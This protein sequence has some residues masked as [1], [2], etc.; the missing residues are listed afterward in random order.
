MK[1]RF[2]RRI[3][4]ALAAAP[5]LLFAVT[6]APSGAM[7][8][9]GER[10]LEG[11][12]G[13]YPASLAI[14]AS[15]RLVYDPVRMAIRVGSAPVFAS[16][17][18]LALAPRYAGR[19]TGRFLMMT[20][21]AGDVD[22]R[23]LEGLFDATSAGSAAP[24]LS[25][26]RAGDQRRLWLELDPGATR[27]KVTVLP[28]GDSITQGNMAKW[29][30]WRI[31]YMK[32]LAAAGYDA[33][34]VGFWQIESQDIC[35]AS[36]PSD[37]VWHS[38]ISGQRIRH[39]TGGTG[40]DYAIDAILDQAG[41]DVDI[42]L[43]KLATNDIDGDGAS[44][45]ELYPSW[46]N[47][48]A[49]IA[50]RLPRAKVV[51]ASVLHINK[52]DRNREVSGLNGMIQRAVAGGVF[53][54]AYFADLNAACPRYDA[55]GAY[56]GNF[57]TEQ[58]LHPD[59][60]GEELIADEY[61]RVTELALADGASDEPPPP[62]PTATGARE[63]V[64]P[65]YLAGFSRA[66]VLDVAKL[67]A[68]MTV[69]GEV[70][71][72]NASGET[73]P[74]SGIRRVGYYV[75]LK[76]RNTAQVDYRGR[77]RWLWVDM[78]AFGATEKADGY[79]LADVGVPL[80]ASVKQKVVSRLHVA[81]NMPGVRSVAADDDSVR[82]F[83]EFWP[84]S[85]TATEKT[86]GPV[87]D[88]PRHVYGYDWNDNCTGGSAWGS[89]QVH[90]I[91]E[92]G[93]YP[94][95]TLFAFNRFTRDGTPPFEIGIGNF[96]IKAVKSADWTQTKGYETLNSAAYEIARIEIWTR[97][98]EKEPSTDALQPVRVATFNIR[99]ENS[100]DT[101]SKSWGDRRATVAAVI[102][103]AKPDVFGL[104][105]VLP[106][107]R[108][109][110]A[111]KLP[112]WTLVGDHRNAD[113]TSG[114]ASPVGYRTSRFDLLA[115][116]TFWLS[117]TPD[118]PGSTSWN[119]AC[120]RICTYVV[121]RDRTDGRSFCF[122]NA[123][124]D[125]KSEK[126]RLNGLKLVLERMGKIAYGMPLVFVG[127]HNCYETQAPA[128][129][130]SAAL[131]NALYASRTA[132]KGPWRSCPGFAV[133]DEGEMP[134]AEVIAATT[135]EERNDGT[136]GKRID[137][138]Y[139][140]PSVT[141]TD[142]ETV[143]KP[144][145][146]LGVYPSDHFPVV[147]TLN[148]FSGGRVSFEAEIEKGTNYT[149][150]TVPVTA[151]VMNLAGV[152]SARLTVTLHGP[153]GVSAV[154]THEI[155]DLENRTFRETF[156]GLVR[157]GR[158]VAAAELRVGERR[159]LASRSFTAARE[160]AVFAAENAAI[161]EPEAKEL[162]NEEVLVRGVM[163]GYVDLA[164]IPPP[165]GKAG[166]AFLDVA[167]ANELV[168]WTDG[169]W[170]RTGVTVGFDTAC[171][172]G[173]QFDAARQS[174]TY[175]VHAVDGGWI[176][177]G[178]AL[179]SSAPLT[180]IEVRGLGAAPALEGR[181]VNSNLIATADGAEYGDLAAA[182]ANGGGEPVTPLWMTTANLP[183]DRLG[184]VAAVD[185]RGWLSF[186]GGLNLLRRETKDGVTRYYY[187]A[188]DPKDAE[189]N[190]YVKTSCELGLKTLIDEDTEVRIDGL[191]PSAADGTLSFSLGIGDETVAN[192][193]AAELVEVC[194]ELA[195]D[196]WHAPRPPEES[197][198]CRDGRIVVRPGDGSR[199]F[200]RAVI[201]P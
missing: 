188:V 152:A 154:R 7:E 199:G 39:T 14:G 46:S 141:V 116:G 34:A 84:Y 200:V 119:T 21:D 155:A 189:G 128:Q 104:Q 5:F 48:V 53:P 40:E 1:T 125:H 159:T 176:P 197:S 187:G 77:V 201:R 22:E 93:D 67:T 85:Y 17:A 69:G 147:A 54:R 43:F 186:A 198:E 181:T 18:K 184:T 73:G 50:A 105:E 158:Y 170:R 68:P 114:E 183:T 193:R 72:E 78:D 126:A 62:V 86:A 191:A 134:A 127:D 180:K 25:V 150:A 129:A 91:L 169:A 13:V 153:D 175:R 24:R 115:H 146:D 151:E 55:N 103:N 161:L 110:L 20:W 174:A 139:V 185:P 2:A 166:V 162:P 92:G 45:A 79:A 160:D 120:P 142:Y 37:W 194:T 121:L 52:D 137:Y 42:V 182:L 149:S 99:Y 66:R 196:A 113:R 60:K 190:P 63:N 172:V 109:Y 145:A 88:G 44:A 168:V 64:P 10:T 59:W 36:M 30:N 71:Y 98:K 87:A 157:G 19:T 51:C 26:E 11:T 27:R 107:Q 156:G 29:G 108:T 101:G 90:R 4:L 31:A 106:A 112:D 94:A 75:E 148:L 49:R 167:T 56:T 136:Y 47:L 179:A 61:L 65:E 76:R 192:A 9:T 171:E 173:V 33:R 83:V 178:D 124:A 38:G 23:S 102:R 144:R 163:E 133:P 3:A 118:K 81:S 32:R 80:E 6:V 15:G 111:K 74:V 97:A 177:L 132:P 95:E 131:S 135:P 8:V 100:S 41:D 89:M 58:N 12:G 130:V 28:I 117:E 70:P 123:H 122:A 164:D 138:V 195:S 35:C 16:G 143:C 82:G 57:Y 165:E 96:A 140:S